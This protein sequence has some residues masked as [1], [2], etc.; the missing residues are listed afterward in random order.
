MYTLAELILLRCEQQSEDLACRHIADDGS[1]AEC[2]YGQLGVMSRMLG[3]ELQARGEIGDRAILLYPSGLEF[4]V[5][6]CG[7]LLAG[8]V[9]V[10]TYPTPG[11]ARLAGIAHDASPKLVLTTEAMRKGRKAFVRSALKLAQVEWLAT[12]KLDAEA[13]P[14]W[15]APALTPETLALLQYTSGST[16]RPKGVKVTHA[17]LLHN[18]RAIEEAFGNDS[19]THMVSWL[20]AYHDMGLIGSLLQ[21]IYLGGSCTLMGP[22]TFLQ[23]PVRWLEAISRFRGTVSGAPNFAYELC[24]RKVRPEELA[25]LDLSSWVVAFNGAEPVRPATLDRFRPVSSRMGSNPRRC[26][27]R[28]DS[29]R[30]RCS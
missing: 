9:A 19:A 1:I 6:F 22:L 16:T 17:N 10:P 15:K 12:D 24:T 26:I 30:P 21:P 18:E 3:A 27:Q 2:T 25:G 20:P 11:S 13:P 4:I 14:A 29:Q 28:M 8:V 5:A 7:C 23:R